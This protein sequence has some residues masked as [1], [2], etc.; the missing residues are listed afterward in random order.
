VLAVLVS[1]AGEAIGLEPPDTGCLALLRVALGSAAVRWP[2]PF[3]DDA[4]TTG[5]AGKRLNRVRT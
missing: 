2:F 4:A 5:G 3:R 1:V